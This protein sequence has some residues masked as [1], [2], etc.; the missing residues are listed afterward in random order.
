MFFWKKKKKK[1]LVTHPGKIGDLLYSLNAIRAISI[2]FEAPVTLLTSTY[3]SSLKSILLLQEYIKDVL[4]DTNYRAENQNRGLQPHTMTIPGKFDH[5]F[6]LGYREQDSFPI[7]ERPLSEYPFFI[8]KEIYGLSLSGLDS[9]RLILKDIGRAE[10]PSPYFVFQCLGETLD[11]VL[12]PDELNKVAT[13]WSAIIKSFGI[14]SVVLTGER[15]IN[16]YRALGL[17]PIVPENFLESAKYLLN[18]KGLIA[19]QSALLALA[20]ELGV[21]RIH[22]DFFKN[23]PPDTPGAITLPFI[24]RNTGSA[25]AAKIWISDRMSCQVK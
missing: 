20:N 17:N 15:E 19:P 12:G 9:P 25:L 22:L 23:A 7:T 21:P 6:Q 3:S 1:I 5:V 13:R 24:G 4:I 16:R 14:S 2:H 8:L 10:I 11:V 18:S